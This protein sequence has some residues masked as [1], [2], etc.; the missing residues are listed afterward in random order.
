MAEC[1]ADPAPSDA[2]A[3]RVSAPAQLTSKHP[4][5][6][7]QRLPARMCDVP[8]ALAPAHSQEGGI[9]LQLPSLMDFAAALLLSDAISKQKTEK[10]TAT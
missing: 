3:I 5:K 10:R 6:S 1:S 8:V 2:T 4:P 9:I 7:S